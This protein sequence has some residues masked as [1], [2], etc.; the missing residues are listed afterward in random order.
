MVVY[1]FVVMMLDKGGSPTDQMEY[2]YASKF[3]YGQLSS[4][5]ALNGTWQN[6]YNVISLVNSALS[7]LD[8][9]AQHL[10]SEND[11]QLNAHVSSGSS[12]FPGIGLFLFSEL[13]GGMCL[14]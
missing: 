14:S 7:S 13:V 9:Y 5:W 1:L 3:Q 2:E 8:N 12:F 11:K 4:F 10:T 6:Y